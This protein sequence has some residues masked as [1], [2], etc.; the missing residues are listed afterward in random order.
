MDSCSPSCDDSHASEAANVR[1]A[2]LA[3]VVEREKNV[4]VRDY[5]SLGRTDDELARHS[6]MNQQGG[7]AVI[8]ARGLKIE[9]EKFAVPSHGGDLA[10]GQGLLHGGRIVDE[11]RFA[12]ANAEKSSAGQDGSKTSRDGFY[13][14]EFRHFCD[15][16]LAHTRSACQ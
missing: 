5:R 8:G 2:E 12:E 13:F 6:Q 16:T 7:A 3:A 10:A 4:S 9:H 14:G 1:V 11:I 15:S